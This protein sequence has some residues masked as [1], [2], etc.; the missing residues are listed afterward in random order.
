MESLKS[1]KSYIYWILSARMVY[2]LKLSMFLDG[3]YL[4]IPNRK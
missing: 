1:S 4:H 3:F 2:I